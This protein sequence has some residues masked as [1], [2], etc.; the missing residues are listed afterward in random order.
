M[1]HKEDTVREALP[2]FT[3]GGGGCAEDHSSKNKNSTIR[4][5][6]ILTPHTHKGCILPSLRD[7]TDVV[8]DLDADL[9]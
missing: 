1:V 6:E 7:N 4:E 2:T 5:G 9:I 8:A 3:K